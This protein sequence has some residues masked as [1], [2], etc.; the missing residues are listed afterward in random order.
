MTEQLEAI[1]KALREEAEAAADSERLLVAYL[2]ETILGQKSL[3]AA[4]SYTLASKLKDEILPSITLRDL[5]LEIF[6]ED[7]KLR[8]AIRI[9]LQAVRDRDPAANGYLSPFLFFKG[10]SA[11][12]AYRFAN[13]LWCDERRPLALYLQS[14]ISRTFGVDIHPA[15]TIGK[16]ILIDHATGVVIGETAVVGDNVSLLHNVT[17]G[18]TGKER[19]DRHPKVGN[20]VLIAAGAKVLGNIT[21]GEG[22][23]IGAGSVVLRS[24][25]PH[26]TVV[27]VPARSIGTC[28]ETSPALGMNQQIDSEDSLDEQ[29]L[30][31]QV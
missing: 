14:L 27:G 1:W 2:Q 26:C 15:A 19:G 6:G 22:A 8:E 4:L 21:I 24:V 13:H 7:E 25:K 9:D 10:F 23:K 5:F 12:S 16:G 3:E 18:G 31:Y 20:G 11:L 29:P 28:G 30:D 17:L